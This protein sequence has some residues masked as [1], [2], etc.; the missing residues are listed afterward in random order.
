M[1]VRTGREYVASLRDD[2]E[3][4]IR[5]ERAR[6]V[7]VHPAFAGIVET[8]A[9]LYDL[10][11][12]SRFRDRITHVG[13]GG[14]RYGN[15]FLPSRSIGDLLKLREYSELWATDQPHLYCHKN[16]FMDQ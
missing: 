15:I 12:D 9:R 8:L 13:E 2:R 10:Q 4:Y 16:M 1:V 11:H 14:E 3:V 7:T 6:D 5:G